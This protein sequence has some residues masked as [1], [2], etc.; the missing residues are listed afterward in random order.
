MRKIIHSPASRALTGLLVDLRKE[1]GMTQEEF[2]DKLGWVRQTVSAIERG[3]RML[4]VLE[5]VEYLKPFNLSASA[6]METLERELASLHGSAGD[7]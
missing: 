2:A 5:L 1:S 7:R 6:F 4:M 3:E